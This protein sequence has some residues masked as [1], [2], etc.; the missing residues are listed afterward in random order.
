[1]PPPPIQSNAGSQL[2]HTTPG[3]S[4]PDDDLRML[5]NLFITLPASDQ[6]QCLTWL[7]A[8][9]TQRWRLG[10]P[11]A[12]E[13]YR[14][15]WPALASDPE[16]FCDLLYHEIEL[17]LE[18]GAVPTI[19][20]YVERFPLLE[21]R[22]RRLFTVH[23]M[24]SD[25]PPM[26]ARP[27]PES[28]TDTPAELEE[29]DEP[30]RMGDNDA[31]GRPRGLT[32]VQ[33]PGYE[34]VKEL[35]RGG[36]GVVY[37]ARQL[38]LNRMVALKM[39]IAGGLAGGVQR[40]RFRAEAEAVA[41]LRHP[42]I[43][44]IFDIGE[45]DGQPYFSL[46]FIDGGCLAE[47]LRKTPPEPADA[48]KLM[49]SMARAVHY[50]HNQDIVHR[51]LKP[52]NILMRRDGTPV[53][54]DFGLAKRLDD[55][56]NNLT[57]TGA[58]LGTASYMAPEQAAGKA[59][60]VGPATDVYSLGAMLYEMLAGHPPFRGDTFEA[61]LLAVLFDMPEPPS[62]QR[63]GVPPEL[64]AICLKCLEKE[65]SARYPSAGALADDLRRFRAGEQLNAAMLDSDR[66]MQAWARRAGFE[67]LDCIGKGT[68]TEVYRARQT[69][70]RR[71]VALKVIR[72]DAPDRQ[73]VLDRLETQAVAGG[74][75]LRRMRQ[76]G[77]QSPP[78]VEIYD[79]GE[80]DGLGYCA[81]EFFERGSV[82]QVLVDEPQPVRTGLE[83]VL[84]IAQALR[85]VH[86]TGHPHGNLKPSNILFATDKTPRLSD[87]T[88]APRPTSG[89]APPEAIAA[90]LDDIR[91]LGLLLYRVLSGTSYTSDAPPLGRLRDDIP[92]DLD[93]ISLR[94]LHA[95]P[96][97][98]YARM[99]DVAHEL[100]Q[101]L[102][103]LRAERPVARPALQGTLPGYELMEQ[104]GRGRIGPVYRARHL[105]TGNLVAVQRV[106][107]RGYAPETDLTLFRQTSEAAKQLIH[108]H[109]RRLNDVID[110][111][112]KTNLIWEYL[113]GGSL[114]QRLLSGP[115]PPSE[116]ARLVE[117][118]AEALEYAH[119]L[120]IYHGD[121]HIGKVLLTATG[122]PKITGFRL[123]KTIEEQRR[124]PA[125]GVFDLQLETRPGSKPPEFLMRQP[126][127]R[128]A[129]PDIYCLGAMLY[130]LILG[131]P[132]PEVFNPQAGHDSTNLAAKVLGAPG[133]TKE[134]ALAVKA[135]LE[136]DAAN[137]PP[138]ATEALK[139]LR[140][141]RGIVDTSKGGWFKRAASWFGG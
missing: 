118:L 121:L 136:W 32:R 44:Q 23:I 30:T 123:V 60:L 115:M 107:P 101:C 128:L 33:V 75:A 56:Q 127:T 73:A 82:E 139:L 17:R 46:E 2:A 58:V 89:S 117:S 95:N 78:L 31:P 113:D 122:I 92:P 87:F 74:G 57:S 6:R 105:D 68:K 135:F 7:R 19:E 98:R 62:R 85:L 47:V 138:S 70:L 8:H 4:G 110:W 111:S 96:V 18:M 134:L 43:V 3:F 102:T 49:E 83:M 129:A 55:N 99:S 88:A 50:A 131:K 38:G 1:V 72:G 130:E 94:C 126:I 28:T 106:E 104:L 65:A 67:L 24:L 59:K 29:P 5:V 25:P 36:M 40:A 76:E 77:V 15:L 120:G 140:A 21:E 26:A 52:A 114:A 116:A 20:E 97:H 48:A 91:Q 124:R 80:R 14:S 109:I 27:K 100:E 41:K 35:G 10:Q 69:R 54:T 81:M 12:L 79:L 22:I 45:H 119:G 34:I 51:D 132:V 42:N 103:H 133:C 86:A 37:Q 125:S 90:E 53:L 71:E 141:S 63:P 137:R 13:E 9:Q 16:A 112:G 61:T 66:W 11:L 39:I 108:P 84:P 64:E 93:A